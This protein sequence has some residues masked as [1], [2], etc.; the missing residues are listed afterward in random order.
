M[1]NFSYIELYNDRLY[2]GFHQVN[3]V[4]V[5]EKQGAIFCRKLSNL[6][7]GNGLSKKWCV[8]GAKAKVRA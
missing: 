4:G 7:H 1:G 6:C 2:I 8:M 5:S 3:G